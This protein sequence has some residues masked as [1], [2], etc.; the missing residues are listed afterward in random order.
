MP[1]AHKVAIIGA[2]MG[3]LALALRLSHRGYEVDIFEKNDFVGGRNHSIQVGESS[4]DSGPTLLM[5]QDPLE[6]LFSDVGE[7]CKD[8]LTITLLDPGYRAWFANGTQIDATTNRLAMRQRVE[9]VG[10]TNAGREFD[11][12]MRDVADLYE[13]SLGPFI[14]QDYLD[15]KEWMKPK[16]LSMALKMGVFGNLWNE[17]SRRFTNDELRMLFSFQTMYLGLSPFQSPW[18]YSTLVHME[19]GE[20]IGYVRGGIVELAETL[21]KLCR[22]RG[23]KIHFNSEV[24][25]IESHGIRF[26][27]GRR[28]ASDTTVC[29]MD[30]PAAQEELLGRDVDSVRG[31]CGALMFYWDVKGQHDKLLHH[32]V[33][34]SSNY[35][36]NFDAI[37]E[38]NQHP[39]DPSFYVCVSSKSDSG[40][41]A[42]GHENVMVLVP[43]PSSAQAFEPQT[44]EAYRQRVVKRLMQEVQFDP[45]AIVAEVVREPSDWASQLGLYRGQAFGL[46]HQLGQSAMFRPKLRDT[47][48]PNLYYVGASTTPGNGIP[49]VLISAELVES[50]LIKDGRC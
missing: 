50:R 49:M 47:S 39:N 42:Q 33:F 29:N 44:V 36:E 26:K 48:M 41:T 38:R 14:R 2:G 11:K 10:G 46:G 15:A 34:F 23:C 30:L 22:A 24:V 28:F 3:G 21:A 1:L 5:M 45:N 9:E 6:K 8:H 43:C 4:F 17:V 7:S 12:L 25:A 13:A 18:V 16:S 27:D 19:Y 37:F 35:R 32:N 20:G 40:R 31:S